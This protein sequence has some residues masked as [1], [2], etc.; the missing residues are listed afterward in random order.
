MRYSPQGHRE[1]DTTEYA[2]VH[3]HT[4]RQQEGAVVAAPVGFF[5]EHL[6]GAGSQ[7]T[8]PQVKE[9]WGDRHSSEGRAQREPERGRG[10][11]GPSGR[12]SVCVCTVQEKQAW[13]RTPSWALP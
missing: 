7:A 5:P 10:R 4:H 12:H 3:A 9:Q 13:Q 2:C 8:I 1:S 11:E 6:L